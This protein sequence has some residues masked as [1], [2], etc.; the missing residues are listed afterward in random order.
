MRRSKE[1][2]IAQA[3][4]EKETHGGCLL[5]L[6]LALSARGGLQMRRRSLPNLRE[7]EIRSF[8]ERLEEEA[9]KERAE[10]V[11][12]LVDALVVHG[13]RTEGQEVLLAFREQL[14]E[15]RLFEEEEGETNRVRRNW[16]KHWL[17]VLQRASR[18]RDRFCRVLH[19]LMHLPD[20]SMD[21]RKGRVEQDREQKGIDKFGEA[22]GD[23][24]KRG[25][26]GQ[27]EAIE[28]T[29]DEE[30]LAFYKDFNVGI[31]G[32]LGEDVKGFGSEAD[33]SCNRVHNYGL[34][35]IEI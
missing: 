19:E 32:E 18:K 22:E 25:E 10:I 26:Q 30:C 35:D 7:E 6:L 12:N 21:E 31:E 2:Y 33:E 15:E 9:S 11:D 4:E 23:E 1:A 27:E 3:A 13:H 29:A 14:L 5:V 20:V 34:R 17:E 24:S 28:D 8:L 16:L